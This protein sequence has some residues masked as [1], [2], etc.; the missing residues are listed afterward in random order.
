MLFDRRRFR[1]LAVIEKHQLIFVDVIHIDVIHVDVIHMQITEPCS[2]VVPD[3]GGAFGP[4][5]KYC[6]LWRSFRFRVSRRFLRSTSPPPAA[7]RT[8]FFPARSVRRAP[9]SP[10]RI[11]GR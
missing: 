9:S 3:S 6:V 11:F 7:A 1:R 4:L 2:P 10:R 8:P 5:E